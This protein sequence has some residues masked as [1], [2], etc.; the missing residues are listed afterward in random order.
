MALPIKLL[1]V[2][3]FSLADMSKNETSIVLDISEAGCYCLQAD[4]TG[5]SPVGNL[6]IMASTN[7][8]QFDPISTNAISGNTGSLIINVERP[9]YF[10]IQLL[11]QFTSGTGT[12]NTTVSAKR[13]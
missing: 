2:P 6:V 9:G 13:I 7:N 1:S 3:L 5:S 4:W 8:I 10:Y 12:L 11:Y